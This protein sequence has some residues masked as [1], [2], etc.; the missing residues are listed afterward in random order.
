MC[1]DSPKENPYTGKLYRDAMTLDI[2]MLKNLKRT[3]KQAIQMEFVHESKGDEAMLRNFEKLVQQKFDDEETLMYR[4]EFNDQGL[5]FVYDGNEILEYG[6]EGRKLKTYNELKNF[7]E[8]FAMHKT[9]GGKLG[10]KRN[11]G[12]KKNSKHIRRCT[13]K[14]FDD[15]I[16]QS[17]VV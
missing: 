8:P 4:A 13:E 14:E 10:A 7:V 17:D 3:L 5:N 15:M 6:V 9:S 2:T 12:G 1:K 16:T 11:K